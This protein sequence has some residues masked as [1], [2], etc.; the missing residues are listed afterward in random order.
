MKHKKIIY[1]S[2]MQYFGIWAP[3]KSLF[4]IKQQIFLNGPSIT[5]LDEHLAKNYIKIR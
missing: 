3:S 4:E 2:N 1:L 5:H